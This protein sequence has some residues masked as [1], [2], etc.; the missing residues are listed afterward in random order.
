ME[1]SAVL[2]VIVLLAAAYNVATSILIY[3]ALK[4]MGQHPSFLLLRLYI[5]RYAGDYR[6]L[7]LA[8][9]GHTGQLFYH[10]VISI[11]IAFAAALTAI[12]VLALA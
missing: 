6:R 5:P 9:S 8:E 7:T 2:L 3:G 1:L 11:N 10:W 12:L 4:K